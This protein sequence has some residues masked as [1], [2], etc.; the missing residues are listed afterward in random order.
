M[1]NPTSTDNSFVQQEHPVMVFCLWPMTIILQ[2]TSQKVQQRT[3]KKE[4]NIVWTAGTRGHLYPQWWSTDSSELKVDDRDAG[5][6]VWHVSGP[7]LP[8]V[9][10]NVS[11][12]RDQTVWAGAKVCPAQAPSG[13]QKWSF[14][15]SVVL[16]QTQV[17]WVI[18][19]PI[20][21]QSAY[22][23][24]GFSFESSPSSSAE[25]FLSWWA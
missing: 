18:F 25:T 1:R 8:Q 24:W 15:R 23:V 4:Y 5:A 12:G 14:K 13:T 22:P 10:V 6:L 21:N 17:R 2:C 3:F 9:T 20:P 16:Q 11:A 7:T 19:H